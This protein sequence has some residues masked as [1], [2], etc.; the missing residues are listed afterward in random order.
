V[1]LAWNLHHAAGCD[2]VMCRK[3]AGGKREASLGENHLW[4]AVSEY[5]EHYHRERN[6]QGVGNRLL[7]AAEQAVRP[8]NG[9]T[10]LERRERLGGLPNLY[11]R[12]TA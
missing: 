5:I 11:Y 1:I 3:S 12:R 10:P 6:H 2:P 7:T 4:R 8:A 9:N